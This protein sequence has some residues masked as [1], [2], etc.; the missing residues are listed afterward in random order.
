MTESVS[1]ISR[2][3]A[4]LHELPIFPLP[5][6]VL[7]PRALLPLHIFEPRYRTMLKDCLETHSAMVVALVPDPHELDANRN[8]RIATVAGGGIV[9]E[10][11]SLPDGRSNILLHGLS[12]LRL[13]ELPF[14]PPYRRARGTILADTSSVVPSADRTALIAAATAFAGEV[15]RRDPNFSLRLPP[16]LEAGAIADL[17]AHHLI[18]D[19]GARQRMLEQLDAAERVHMVIDELA[20]QHGALLKEGGG[21]LH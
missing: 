16:S 21:R 2:L 5:Q 1:K 6:I 15:H 10:H 19:A 11:Q 18:I 4:A 7:F 17:C 14:V 13:E 20:H 3:E 12:R 9:I 8:P